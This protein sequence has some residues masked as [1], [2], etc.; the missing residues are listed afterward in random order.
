[1]DRM[2]P[3][4]AFVGSLIAQTHVGYIPEVLVSLAAASLLRRTRLAK[5]LASRLAIAPQ[6]RVATAAILLVCWAPPLYEALTGRPGNLQRLVAFFTPKHLAEHSWPAAIASVSDQLS[7][8]PLAIVRAAHQCRRYLSRHV[9]DDRGR[10]DH[11]TCG[12]RRAGKAAR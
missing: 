3:A 9:V 11:R 5:P 1:N 10:P 4:L 2:L 6:S 8:M 7:V 12:H